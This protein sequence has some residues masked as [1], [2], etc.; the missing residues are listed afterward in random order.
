MS[1]KSDAQELAGIQGEIKQLRDRIRILK[2]Q[3]KIV[4]GRMI[5]YMKENNHDGVTCGNEKFVLKDRISRRPM[6]ENIRDQSSYDILRQ[7]G[8]DNPEAAFKEMMDARRGEPEMKEQIK[9]SKF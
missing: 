4:E 6:K 2:K 8:V 9:I 5:R 1:V 7:H 3:E